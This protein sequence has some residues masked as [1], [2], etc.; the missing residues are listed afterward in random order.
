[1]TTWSILGH[2]AKVLEERRDDYGDPAEQFRAIADRWS[3][4]LGTPITPAQVALCM[5]DLKLARLAYD[6]G[7][8]DSLVDV[9]GYAALLRE[10][11]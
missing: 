11:R 6:P 3:I 8:F 5:I 7:H 9:I 10:V 4:T 1:M 2:T